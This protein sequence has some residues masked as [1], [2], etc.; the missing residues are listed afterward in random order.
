MPEFI[1]TQAPPGLPPPTGSIGDDLPWPGRE[2]YAQVRAQMKESSDL[3]PPAESMSS[4]ERRERIASWMRGGPRSDGPGTLPGDALDMGQWGP[5][6]FTRG[7]RLERSVP[8]PTPS[9]EDDHPQWAGG[10][11]KMGFGPGLRTPFDAETPEGGEPSSDGDFLMATGFNRAWGSPPGLY[12][13]RFDA[14]RAL[15]TPDMGGNAIALGGPAGAI[16][17]RME[18][19]QKEKQGIYL[20]PVREG[21]SSSGPWTLRWVQ[22]S[23]AWPRVEQPYRM[24]GTA[25][26][27]RSVRVPEP[28][29]TWRS[30]PRQPMSPPPSKGIGPPPDGRYYPTA[31]ESAG[32]GSDL[33]SGYPSAAELEDWRRA[34]WQGGKLLEDKGKTQFQINQERRAWIQA[35]QGLQFGM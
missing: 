5:D 7:R 15:Y 3:P 1:I 27:P 32:G 18:A 6:S 11:P 16:Q 14:S 19:L 25:E 22:V 4:D 24:V 34:A 8:Q 9:P 17:L 13:L 33:G 31:K 35:M 26:F 21:A 20:Q 12:G 29:P 28:Q 10:P 2:Q 30:P 23:S